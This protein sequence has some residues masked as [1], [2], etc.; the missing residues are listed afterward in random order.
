VAAA[1]EV[2]VRDV[3][4]ESGGV[5]E[6]VAIKIITRLEHKK[7]DRSLKVEGSVAIEDDIEVVEIFEKIPLVMVMSTW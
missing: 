7:M 2:E 1:A 4:L 5:A 6:G 3:V